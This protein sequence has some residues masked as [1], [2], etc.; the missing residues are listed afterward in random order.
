LGG[1]HEF[2]RASHAV[3][4]LLRP[5]CAAAHSAIQ[6]SGSGRHR[7]HDTVNS[8][9]HEDTFS[10]RSDTPGRPSL[11]RIEIPASHPGKLVS[12]RR[13]RT[14]QPRPGGPEKQ[15]PGGPEKQRPGGPENSSP[16]LAFFVVVPRRNPDRPMV[17]AACLRYIVHRGA[18]TVTFGRRRIR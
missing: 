7:R 6:N 15:R 9:E 16:L 5:G 8:T 1:N 2:S 10:D 14:S 12:S 13:D 11:H 17:P 3:A 4:A 18:I